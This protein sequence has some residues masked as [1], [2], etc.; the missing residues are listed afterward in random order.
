MRSFPAFVL[1]FVSALVLVAAVGV[2]ARAKA[3]TWLVLNG[4]A[5]HLDSG[6]YC[7]NHV[8][9][10]LGVERDGWQVGF[11]DNS[12]CALSTYVAKSWLPVRIEPVRIGAILGAVSGY[13]SYPLPAVGLAAA[14]ER[15]RWGANLIFIPPMSESSVGVMWLQFKVRLR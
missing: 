7:N 11:Y 4:L 14:Y 1:G 2:L 12:N 3:D 15:D 9:K 5:Q 6:S 8:T 13:A 10:G